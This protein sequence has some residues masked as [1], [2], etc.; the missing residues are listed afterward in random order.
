MAEDHGVLFKIE[1][2]KL[3]NLAAEQ[4]K[5]LADLKN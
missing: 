3:S 5:K 1:K 2:V 4:S